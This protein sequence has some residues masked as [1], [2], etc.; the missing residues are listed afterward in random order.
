MRSGENNMKTIRDI[1]YHHRDNR[2]GINDF[3]ARLVER[4]KTCPRQTDIK[5]VSSSADIAVSTP[6]AAKA[7]YFAFSAADT[8]VAVR[9]AAVYEAHP[10]YDSENNPWPQAARNDAHAAADAERELQME[11]LAEIFGVSP[12]ASPGT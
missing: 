8:L 12:S 10:E 7:A 1:L 4:A 5:S 11:D 6:N 9:A 3:C 2:D